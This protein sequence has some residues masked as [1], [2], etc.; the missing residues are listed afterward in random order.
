MDRDRALGHQT[1]RGAP[2]GQLP[3]HDPPHTRARG[4]AARS[5][6][7]R[8]RARDDD[9]RRSRSFPPGPTSWLP[10][11][12]RSDSIR[13]AACS[14]DNRTFPEVFELSWILACNTWKGI[15]NRAHAYKSAKDANERAGRPPDHG[16]SAGLYT[17]PV[18]M[19]AD[20]L[21]VGATLVPVGR[22]QAQHLEIAR[23]L[24]VA[25]N[26]QFGPVLRIPSAV[27]DPD[28]ATI[29][30]TDGRKMSKSYDNV[31]P[32]FA[33]PDELRR[34]IRRVVTDSRSPEEPK[35]PES[36]PLFALYRQ[37]ASAQATEVMATRYRAGDVGY[38]EMKDAVA[39]LIEGRFGGARA[40]HTELLA[41]RRT[42]NTILA[43]GAARARRRAKTV[44]AAVR[45]A[46]VA[47]LTWWSC[48]AATLPVFR[49]GRYHRTSCPR[50]VPNV[51]CVCSTRELARFPISS[52]PNLLG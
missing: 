7:H 49:W 15:L 45:A 38:G 29:V 18:L 32:I 44:M 1:L 23:E 37:L 40:H 10:R 51:P 4:P 39:G 20:I 13:P 47:I 5:R 52:R 33:S 2:F 26:Q 9:G 14:I 30:G 35:N 3:G 24:S 25:F 22:D 46:R 50:A 42:L 17:Y 28:A 11:C 41:D 19:A 6:V 12:W 27:I 8:R 36:C 31:I 34:R 48:E 16:V 43:S 21:V